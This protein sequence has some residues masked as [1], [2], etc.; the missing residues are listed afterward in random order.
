[1][2]FKFNYI[3]RHHQNYFENES[4]SEPKFDK[5]NEEMSENRWADFNNIFQN[6]EHSGKDVLNKE[7][8]WEKKPE[9]WDKSE[10]NV[11]QEGWANFNSFN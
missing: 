2:N 5:S 7:N 6:N 4:N 1:M 8:P 9:S 3:R 11:E 10:D